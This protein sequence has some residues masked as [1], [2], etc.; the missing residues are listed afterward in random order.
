MDIVERLTLEA[1]QADTMLACEHRH[2]YEFAAPLCDGK[3]V[4]DLCCGS[5]YGSA[6]LAASA[7]E[8]LGVDNDAATV[9]TARV[10]VGREVANLAF[11]AADAIAF[12]GGD[13]AERFDVVVCFEGLEHLRDLDRA[14]GL[15]RE[16]AQRGL[17]IVASLPNSKMLGEDNPYHVTNLDYEGLLGLFAGFPEAV[18]VPQ[19]LAEGSL[20][21]P[22]GA[23]E[24]DV[25]VNVED[26]DEPEYA[27]HLI[28]CVG[29]ESAVID[30]A[31]HGRMRLS[32]S[33]V[34]NRWSE[35]LK[36]GAW[37]LR[38]ENAR[39]GRERLGKAGSAAATLLV[40]SQQHEAE[41][42][43]WKER[44][45]AAEERVAQLDAALVALSRP[46]EMIA[47][48]PVRLV[49]RA[50]VE[51]VEARPVV[52]EPGEDPNSWEQ[53]RRRAAEVLIPWIEQTVPLAGKTVLEYGC[54][55]AAVSCAFAERAKRVI[56]VDIDPTWIEL[57]NEELAK[58]GLKNVQLELHPIE[59]ILGAVAAR[60]GQI[61]VFLLYAVLEHLTIEERLAV[62]RL[63]REVVKPDG[64]IVVCE[65][66]NRL[67]YFDHHTAQMPFFHLLP[68]E[69]ALE[70]RHRS[71]RG[72][73]K[74]ALDDAAVAGHAAALEALVRL[75]RG[76]S[77]HEFEVV[78]GDL[79]RHVIASNYDPLLFGE[80]PVHPD[81]VI[82][83]RYLE[84]WRPDLAPVWSR[85]WLDVILS[86]QPVEKRPPFIRPWSADTDQSQDVGWTAWENL[87][88]K[89]PQSTLWV[90]LPK[91]T[92][93]LVVGSITQDGRWLVLYARPEDSDSPLIANHA[94]AA[95]I[96]AFSSFDLPAPASRIALQA[97][98]DCHVVFVGYED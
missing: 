50:P 72:E 54:G 87:H 6:I 89:G 17:R 56:G 5:G 68:E 88:F 47:G 64:A 67:I 97:S 2:R 70:Y 74:Q 61:D 11:E 27:N 34:F 32:A 33:P 25:D 90:T 76:V 85:Y 96:T 83:W 98:D 7:L 14:L 41:I 42:A 16:H 8:V 37:A 36:R 29:F 77:F 82:L 81:E 39:L 30:R 40:R 94:A 71:D 49:T 12:L 4:L 78:F 44:C 63:A 57:G 48:E 58:H 23:R 92:S 46:A 51:A 26:R 73:I 35:D 38:R 9:D 95:R 13:I 66:P 15:L 75:G 59:T 28:F 93:R 18:V 10:T 19:F 43:A 79:S 24:T 1:A 91:P 80:R 31:H 21:C 22:P 69:L 52:I 60:R 84:R 3:R 62:L 86:P 65:A 45:R 20:I 53:R 55:N